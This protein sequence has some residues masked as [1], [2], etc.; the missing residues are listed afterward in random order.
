[1]KGGILSVFGDVDT[2]T[3]CPDGGVAIGGIDPLA[4]AVVVLTVLNCGW[5]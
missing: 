3:G 1:M 5:R 4:I 2:T